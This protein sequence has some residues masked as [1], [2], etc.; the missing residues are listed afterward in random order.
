MVGY[1]VNTGSTED[2]ADGWDRV[3]GCGKP[4]AKPKVKAKAKPKAAAKKP[5]AGAKRK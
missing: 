5:K 2:F 4:K 1:T 3:F